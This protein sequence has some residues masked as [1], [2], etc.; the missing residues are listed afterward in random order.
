MTISATV[1]M[2]ALAVILQ[3]LNGFNVASLP[4]KYQYGFTALLTALQGAQAIVA[5]YYTPGGTA[6]GA[7]STTVTV[8]GT[9][10]LANKPQA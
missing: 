4:P 6:I 5:H 1:I 7:A 8:G 10:T 2:Q 3:I 9:T